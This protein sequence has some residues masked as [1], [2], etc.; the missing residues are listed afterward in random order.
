MDVT[1][2]TTQA[3]TPSSAVTD[4]ASPAVYRRLRTITVIATFG[5]LLFGYDTGV[6]SGALPFMYLSPEEGGLGLTPLTGGIV[7]SSLV[8][9]AAFARFGRRPMLLTGQTGV[10]ISLVLIA[11]SSLVLPESAA[12]S[13]LVLASMLTFLLFMQGCIATAFWLMLSETFP[14]RLRGFAMG[15]RLR[16]LDGQLPGHAGVP[17]TDRRDRRTTFASTCAP[18]PRPGAARWKPSSPTSVGS[19]PP[20]HAPSFRKA[21]P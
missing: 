7:A 1:D 5:G 6:I 13:Y 21:H 2:D 16:H 8:L 19:T 20:D 11:F 4:H 10:T 14:L 15:T 12:R 3:P 9:G 18:F 17:A